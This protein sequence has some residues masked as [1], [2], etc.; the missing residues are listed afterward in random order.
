[1]TMVDDNLIA[2]ICFLPYDTSCDFICFKERGCL[3]QKPSQLSAAHYSFSYRINE[4]INPIELI[5]F[6]FGLLFRK[7]DK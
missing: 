4:N 1:M 7:R 2:Q 3:I 5:F 6:E